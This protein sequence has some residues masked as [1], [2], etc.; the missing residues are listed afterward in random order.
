[1]MLIIMTSDDVGNLMNGPNSEWFQ[2]GGDE[3]STVYIKFED[4]INKHTQIIDWIAKEIVTDVY[5][6]I[7]SIDIFPTQEEIDKKLKEIDDW[8]NAGWI[9]AGKSLFKKENSREKERKECEEKAKEPTSQ[10]VGY[11]FCFCAA[12]DALKF[13]LVWG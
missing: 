2:F 6:G 8:V 5:T 13:K 7:Y 12:D 10:S 3:W 1:M 11:I 9:N 4:L